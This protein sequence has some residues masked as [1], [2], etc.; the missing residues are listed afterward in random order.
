[1]HELQPSC[2]ALNASQEEQRVVCTNSA[3]KFVASSV[4]S[5]GDVRMHWAH[6]YQHTLGFALR[7]SD[8]LRS[9]AVAQH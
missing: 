5:F 8:M 3:S 4:H 7:H 2:A 6:V 1:M 9:S